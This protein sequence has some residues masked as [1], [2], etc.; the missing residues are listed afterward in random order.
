M[1]KMVTIKD[2]HGELKVMYCDNLCNVDV[3]ITY[4]SKFILEVCVEP[5]IEK[6]GKIYWDDYS[7]KDGG[8]IFMIFY[9]KGKIIYHKWNEKILDKKIVKD[10]FEY[11]INIKSI[12]KIN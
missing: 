5:T 11:L 9:N 3:R 8:K 4:L 10:I 12:S 6:K 7:K 2:E 1:N